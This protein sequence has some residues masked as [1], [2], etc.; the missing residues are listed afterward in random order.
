MPAQVAIN[1]T[2]CKGA[3]PIPGAKN[4]R[5]AR[6]SAGALGWRL[7]E[8]E[9]RAPTPRVARSVRCSM[10]ASILGGVR[11][12][13]A[14]AFAGGRAGQGE[15]QDRAGAGSPLRE[16]VMRGLPRARHLEH[17]GFGLPHVMGSIWTE[18]TCTV[19]ALQEC[20]LRGLATQSCVEL[21][22]WIDC[23]R[24][25]CRGKPSEHMH[26]YANAHAC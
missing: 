6:E 8:D 15:Q 20:L 3:I 10:G 7:T 14:A 13:T 19:A 11:S 22:R 4:A 9:V 26:V 17:S 1:W 18:H 12:G 21:S 25:S 16:V 23:L 2:L 24:R 5:Q